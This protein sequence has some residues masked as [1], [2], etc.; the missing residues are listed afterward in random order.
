MTLRTLL[1]CLSLLLL[2]SCAQNPSR[3][4]ELPAGAKVLHVNG[5]DMAFVERGVGTPIVLIHGA[6]SDFRYFAG[7]MEALSANHRVIAVSL[8]HYYPEPWKGDGGSFS[9]RQHVSDIAG[10]IRALNA[11]PVHL[12]GHSRGG[13]LV[14]Y[15]ASQHPDL[16]RSLGVGEGGSN[17]PAFETEGPTA[18]AAGAKARQ[19][20]R[21]ALALFEQGKLEE[22]LTYFVNDVS[23]PGAWDAASEANRQMYR[24]NAWTLK[25]TTQ[26]IFDPYSCADAGRIRVPVLLVTGE[27]TAPLFKNITA[28]IQA[29]LKRSERAVVVNGSHS[30][31]RQ[32]P[33]GFSEALLAFISR[34]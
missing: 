15:F 30:F 3:N 18:L 1:V 2:A 4:W 24:A 17:M 13:S 10:F 33:R 29:C 9:R 22:G 27:K 31:P 26:D 21:N 32:N 25:G 28:A 8:R 6:L 20:A 5:Y 34:H 19:R 14:L 7:A 16:I 23:G 11:G 12:F